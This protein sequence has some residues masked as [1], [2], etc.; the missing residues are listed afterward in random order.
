MLS[1]RRALVAD[2]ETVMRNFAAEVIER[3]GFRVDRVADGHAAREKLD[4]D[5]YDLALFDI[6]MPGPG[7]LDLLAS[8]RQEGRDTAV[9]IM[10][11][12]AS[13]DAAVS[14]LRLGARDFVTKPFTA[15]DLEIVVT[16]ALEA[17]R[18][19]S[20]N[21]RLRR[22]VRRGG[23]IDRILGTSPVITDLKETALALAGSR[24]TV[25][26]TG[27]SGV[28]K[29]LFARALHVHSPRADRPFVSINC[30]AL[31]EN[32]LESELFGHEKG[33]FTGAVARQPGKFELADGGTLLLDEV[34][35]IGPN[36]QPKLLR[37]LQEREFYRVGGREP[38][39]VDVRVVAV[40]NQD[41]QSA[42]EAGRFRRDLYYRLNVV[43]L[44]VPRLAERAV[45]VVPLAEH[46][47]KV[48]SKEHERAIRGFTPE[49]SALLERHTWPGNVRE[50]QNVIERT[51]IL[52]RGDVV[53]AKDIRLE[54]ETDGT[55]AL[56][57][58]LPED[59]ESAEREL[60]LEA[61]RLEGDNRT[62][63]ARRLGISLR[64]LRNKLRKYGVPA[65]LPG[66][67]R[68]A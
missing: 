59:L 29:E 37:V 49:A 54:A 18:L 51:V 36:L 58:A 35:E 1:E 20:E 40:T 46:F 60:I 12:F 21:R 28:G 65:G 7:G 41:L 27:E 15:D 56:I 31:P 44:H 34:G 32:L 47:L 26:I 30:A 4:T 64:T 9:I 22:E 3:M 42:V 11:A 17:G 19:A 55:Q 14:A 67:K 10:T 43:P 45:D 13:V 24:A 38:V 50:L 23:G 39:R 16:R 53:D 61:V 2:D 5:T 52:C 66:A 6:R 8:A 62:R 68:A 57:A 33:A 63:A 48:S 25:L